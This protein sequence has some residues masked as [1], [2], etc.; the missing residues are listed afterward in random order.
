MRIVC[1]KDERLLPRQRVELLG[2]IFAD[3]SVERLGDDL[4]VELL[5]LDLDIVG[6]LEEFDLGGGGFIDGNVVAF[7]P[8]D[9]FFG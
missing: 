6:S 5:D 9:A 1:A 3:D 7:F 4:A 8:K 2:E